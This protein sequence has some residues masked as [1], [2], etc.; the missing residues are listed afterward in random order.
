MEIAAFASRKSPAARSGA[1]RPTGES[2]TEFRTSG[3]ESAQPP[4]AICQPRPNFRLP[5]ERRTCAALLHAAGE[6]RLQS[7]RASE[8][9]SLS[10]C[11]AK[12]E[13]PAG[14]GSVNET[15]DDEAEEEADAVAPPTLYS[16]MTA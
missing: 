14:R 16:W 6:R 3:P 10:I 13:A 11:C 15:R 9:A 8:T 4:R 2:P 5:R 1:E 12:P 7:S